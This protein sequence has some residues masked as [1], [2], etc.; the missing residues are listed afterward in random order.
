MTTTGESKTAFQMVGDFHRKFELP[1]AGEHDNSPHMVDGDTA[2]FRLNFLFEE[3]NELRKGMNEQ[4]IFQV[5][6]ALVD[7][8]Y[9]ALGTAHYYGLPFDALFAEV[10]RVNMLKVRATSPEQS[11]RGTALDVVKPVGWIGPDIK[12]VLY[13]K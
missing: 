10:Q 4:D 6:D 13:G 5:A 2:M 1:V 9:V 7:L 12:R 3:V 11:K 8:V